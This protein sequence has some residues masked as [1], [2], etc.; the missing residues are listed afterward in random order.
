MVW[1]PT[2]LS[3]L[4]FLIGLGIGIWIGVR[5]LPNPFLR[6]L[7]WMY[8]AFLGAEAIEF[9]FYYDDDDESSGGGD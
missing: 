8:L 5:R 2:L 7:Y 3:I 4:C 6:F 1:L 9:E